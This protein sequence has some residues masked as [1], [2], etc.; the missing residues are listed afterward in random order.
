MHDEW[1]HVQD[2]ELSALVGEPLSQNPR[3]VMQPITSL[4]D[5]NKTKQTHSSWSSLMHFVATKDLTA[6]EKI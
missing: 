2:G 5:E 6:L 4:P 1:S 3:G